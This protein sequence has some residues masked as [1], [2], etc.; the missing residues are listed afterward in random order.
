MSRYS[1]I[2]RLADKKL[3]IIDN[4]NGLSEEVTKLEQTIKEKEKSLKDWNTDITQDVER[5]RRI[6]E[7]EINILNDRLLNLKS[8]VENKKK[9]Y[10]E[11]IVEIDKSIKAIEEISKTAPTP[12]EQN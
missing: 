12:Q 6:K 4:K 3:E 10:E 11:K 1:I 8:N 7:Q 9:H 5:T 2:E